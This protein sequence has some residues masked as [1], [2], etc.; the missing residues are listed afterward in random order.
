[1]WVFVQKL[2]FICLPYPW[3]DLKKS[4]TP[5]RIMR[6]PT[7]LQISPERAGLASAYPPTKTKATDGSFCCIRERYRE[8]PNMYIH[9]HCVHLLVLESLCAWADLAVHECKH[10]DELMPNEVLTSSS[11]LLRIC[12]AKCV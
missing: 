9:S 1:M 4:P 2:Q 6:T 3:L 11:S 12:G 5:N 10:N 7:Q 8:T